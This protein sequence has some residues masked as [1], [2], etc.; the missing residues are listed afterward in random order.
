MSALMLER[1]SLGGCGGIPPADFLFRCHDDRARMKAHL[2]QIAEDERRH[3][4]GTYRRLPL[5]LVRGERWNVFDS[6]GR[7]YLD[8]VAGIAVNV[9]GH[10]HPKVAEALHRQALTLV[11]TSNLY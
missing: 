1:L 7:E 2:D 11:H 8:F 4:M 10:A 5:E 3:L 6:E 9:L